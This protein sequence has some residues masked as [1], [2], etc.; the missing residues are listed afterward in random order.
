MWDE[1]WDSYTN[2]TV[3]QIEKKLIKYTFR[4]RRFEHWGR[5]HG[6]R[7]L[8]AVQVSHVDL[9]LVPRPDVVYDPKMVYLLGVRED[10]VENYAYFTDLEKD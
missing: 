1:R 6:Y 5:G 4:T 2:R 7:G 8:I 3:S 9:D 10:A